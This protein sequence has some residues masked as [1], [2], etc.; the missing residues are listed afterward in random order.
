MKIQTF[1]MRGLSQAWYYICQEFVLSGKIVSMPSSLFMVANHKDEPRHL[2]LADSDVYGSVIF[3][4][5]I[6]AC[7]NK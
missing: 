2:V 7:F 4:I 3:L 6:Q 5:V 1:L